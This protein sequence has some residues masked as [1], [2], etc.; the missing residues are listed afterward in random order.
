MGEFLLK[1]LTQLLL[2][3]YLLIEADFSSAHL[4]NELPIDILNTYPSG[5]LR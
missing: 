4:A 1:D 2:W 5:F 3:K